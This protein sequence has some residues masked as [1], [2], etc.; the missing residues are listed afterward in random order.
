MMIKKHEFVYRNPTIEEL[1]ALDHEARRMRAEAVNAAFRR[2][3]K[4]LRAAFSRNAAA[5]PPAPRT[6]RHA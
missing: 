2:A 4:A 5:L 1:Y 6:M 3:F